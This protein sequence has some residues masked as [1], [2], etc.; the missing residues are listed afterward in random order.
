MSFSIVEYLLSQQFLLVDVS[1]Q[2]SCSFS[3]CSKGK[4]FY[5]LLSPSKTHVVVSV[6]KVR[7]SSDQSNAKQLCEDTCTLITNL[8]DHANRS[9]WFSA[10]SDANIPPFPAQQICC[11]KRINVNY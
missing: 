3:I 9:L 8:N 7:N 6:A 10:K 4:K 2:N 5:F 1:F 11:Q